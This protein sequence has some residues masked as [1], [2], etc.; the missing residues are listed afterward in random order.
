MVGERACPASEIETL[1][2]RDAIIPPLCRVVLGTLA[3]VYVV[4][5][6]YVETSG[7]SIPLVLFAGVPVGLA[8]SAAAALLP[9]LSPRRRLHLCLGGMLAG[10]AICMA[11][12]GYSPG[13]G[14][15]LLSAIMLAAT[16]GSRR[17]LLVSVLA[18]AGLF[19]AGALLVAVGF[20]PKAVL[21]S[22]VEPNAWVRV[23]AV[24]LILVSP[25]LVLIGTVVRRLEQ[26][27]AAQQGLLSAID[28][29]N[30]RRHRA[31]VLRRERERALL[32]SERMRLLGRMA[33]GVAHEQ[34]NHL[35]VMI[36]WVDLLRETG[37]APSGA[38]YRAGVRSM[39]R[40]ANDAAKL[41]RSLMSF[42]GGEPGDAE[43]CALD[44]TIAALVGLL[45]RV[46]PE[47]VRLR[48]EAGARTTD[49]A[50]LCVAVSD[51]VVA[52]LLLHVLLDARDP[53]EDVA[54]RTCVD[55]TGHASVVVL[56]A[57]LARDGADASRDIVRRLAEQHACEAMWKDGAL[58]LRL[59][60]ATRAPRE[61]A[62]DEC[63]LDGRTI[64]LVEDDKAT[65]AVLER[66]LLLAGAD[67]LCADGVAAGLEIARRYRRCIDAL[68]ADHDAALDD[69][70]RLVD[71]FRAQ[72]PASP[73][74]L[75]VGDARSTPA[76][77]PSDDPAVAMLPKPFT[78]RGLVSALLELLEPPAPREDT[79]A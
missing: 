63:G 18:S 68:C 19:A 44:P 25:P 77:R 37:C 17:A 51:R 62:G 22:V 6:V 21:V 7:L 29:A 16:L 14:L 9:G 64:L 56:G 38:S 60:L 74:L 79:A 76:L 43:S 36:G 39:L 72:H 45:E 33:E 11:D 53:R 47:D 58:T 52:Q 8:T 48:F 1:A 27:R 26:M 78:G 69:A 20:E 50:D 42:H 67:V 4:L 28:A 5:I 13:L 31:D 23:G 71:G 59:P 32:A 12:V 75:L 73:V 30:R 40:A 54:I 57:T 46:L 65:L 49:A 15:G 35:L 34:N 66:T 55:G 41:T 3:C 10:I 70:R 2:W 24:F 61:S